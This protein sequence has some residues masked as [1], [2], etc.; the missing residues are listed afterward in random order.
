VHVA[1]QKAPKRRQ[2]FVKSSARTSQSTVAIQEQRRLQPIAD[3]FELFEVLCTG[4]GAQRL[5][6]EQLARLPHL[7]LEPAIAPHGK[8][9]SRNHEEQEESNGETRAV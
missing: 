3:G 4:G 1:R 9:A 7:V 8:D 5:A 2:R 6:H